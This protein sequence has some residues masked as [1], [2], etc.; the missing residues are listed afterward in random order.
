M[1]GKYA[2]ED[3][4]E[5]P[6]T[7]EVLWQ[8]EG[9][10]LAVF[11]QYNCNAAG[12]NTRG[13]EIEFR[14]TQGTLYLNQSSYEI[15]PEE[16]REEPLPARSPLRRDEDRRASR[17][18]RRALEAR[19]KKGDPADTT[20]AHARNFLDC[21]KSRKP[22]IVDI[23]TGHRSTSTTQVGNIALKTRCYLE[24]DGKAE[25]F[26]NNEAANKLLAYRYRPPYKLG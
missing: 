18:Q 11:S 8:Y 22:C 25:R 23:E 21:I 16:M 2:V 14:G 4:R 13:S 26:T 6:D 24:W 1:G 19:T 9:G 7:L 12:G 17:A 3:N 20:Q 10:T 5:I 15:V